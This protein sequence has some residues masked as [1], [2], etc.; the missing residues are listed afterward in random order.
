[1]ICNARTPT[2]T[3]TC[4]IG[5][6]V[7][8]KPSVITQREV[9]AQWVIE[10]SGTVDGDLPALRQLG[11]SPSSP[12]WENL[13]KAEMYRERPRPVVGTYARLSQVLLGITTLL[14]RVQ[15]S[16]KIHS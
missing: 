9:C 13:T 10:W 6:L 15:K 11:R 12:R 4:L 8:P 2:T 3:L 14:S 1:M 5:V 16:S 7:L